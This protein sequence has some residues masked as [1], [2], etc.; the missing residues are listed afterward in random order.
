MEPT[1]SISSFKTIK[2]SECE[3]E[4]RAKLVRD[5]RELLDGYHGRC[6]QCGQCFEPLENNKLFDVGG[7]KHTA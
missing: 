4:I 3:R 6:P 5:A 7:K 1:L 2:C